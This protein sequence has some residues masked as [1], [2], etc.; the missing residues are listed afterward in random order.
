MRSVRTSWICGVMVFVSCLPAL[1]A[2]FEWR[3]VSATGAHNITDNTI[4]LQ[5]GGQEVTL[6]LRISGWDFDTNG[7]PLLGAFQASVDPA[8]YSAGAGAALVPLGW[9]AT[10]GDGAFQALNLCTVNQMADPNGAPCASILDCP[11]GEFCIPNTDWAFFGILF[12]L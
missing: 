8:G 11:N 12:Y 10:P 3:P 1:G 5:G 7:D 6:H 9:P 2:E 4:V